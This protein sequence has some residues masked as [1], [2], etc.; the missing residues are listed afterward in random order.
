M[1]HILALLV[2][3]ST[4]L[5]PA[6]ELIRGAYGEPH[7]FAASR[8]A[9]FFWAGYSVAQDRL[10][11]MDV[12]R[13]S[14]R[15]RLA[16]LLGKTALNSDR[17][18]IRFGYT[19]S[20][21]DTLFSKMSSA[22]QK[23][24]ESY[25]NGVNSWIEEATTNKLLPAS[26]S[27]AKP[28]AWSVR[29]SLA[30]GV[31]LVRLFG[32]GG[33]GEIRNLLLYTYLK[34]KMG[35][36]TPKAIEDIAWL[37]DESASTTCAKEDDPFKGVSPFPALA[38]NALTEHIKLLP[39][40]N[41]LELLPGIRLEEQSAMKEIAAQY[42]APYKTGSYA[43]VVSPA[44][45][46]LGVPLLLSAPQMGFQTPSIVHQMSINC[47][48]YVAVGL[49]VPGIPGVLIGHT[50]KFAWGLTSGVADTDDVFVVKLNPSNANQYELNGKWT[51]FEKSDTA[52]EV[53]GEQ[54]ANATRELSAYG[55]VVIKSVGTGVA[56]C[57]KSTL[58]MEET[59]S[60]DG[61][62]QIPSCQTIGDL[63]KLS[64]K[65]NASF[66]LFAATT[67]GDIGWFFCGRVPMRAANVD[68]RLPAPADG[69]HD[70][71][72]VL[73][74]SKMPYMIN[75]K[76]GWIA[77]WNN[78]PVSWW[79][80]S[81]TP[82][83]GRIFRNQA[84]NEVMANRML[85]PQDLEANA[86]HIATH[87]S[88]PSHFVREILSNVTASTPQ[89]S[90][91]L[92]YLVNWSN[93]FF[94]GSVAPRLYRNIFARLQEEIFLEKT[95]NFLSPATFA[96][97]IQPTLV[98]NALHGKTKVNWLGKR[99]AKQ[100]MQNAFSK[101]IAGMQSQSGP[102]VSDWRYAASK[103]PFGSISD[104]LYSNR[105]TYIQVVELFPEPAGRFVAPPGIAED[106]KSKHYGDQVALAANWAFY[107]MLWRRSEFPS[108]N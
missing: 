70:W 59:V 84:L 79:P 102:N 10:F 104:A 53:R 86:R 77:N 23:D 76:K 91:A 87:E 51:D 19:D 17:D 35:A 60:L 88:E 103:L 7:I 83:W 66:N 25:A 12:S 58:W 80:N 92:S 106:P 107:P 3:G 97:V 9:A 57:R 99:T 6:G 63:K 108:K 16:A 2:V 68:P 1:T 85:S 13:R 64:E 31:N 34:D 39:K 33:A 18:A 101:A 69:K 20:E 11:Q 4:Q 38:P 42:G 48:D 100:V 36:D 14:A 5:T 28:E 32:K 24:Y 61:A 21:Y 22:A 43:M 95:G 52:I 78:K 45:S 56:Y 41:L 62:M 44:K 27:G 49:D 47:P 54:A 89:E 15:G 65:L 72:G 8:S 90:L 74:A 73:P 82:V 37:M 98:W 40:V 94:D 67:G 96:Q 105:G 81:D 50:P 29:D 75:P 71:L 30:I 55:P 26:Y 46:S 93:E